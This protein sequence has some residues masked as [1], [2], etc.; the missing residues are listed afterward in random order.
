MKQRLS[1]TSFTVGWLLETL[2][3]R[4][5][6]Y[7][8]ALKGRDVESVSS[9]DIS[10][11]KGFVSCVYKCVIH[12]TGTDDTYRV[13]M[14]VPGVES[15]NK[16][17]D[18]IHEKGGDSKADE[19]MEHFNEIVPRFHKSECTFYEKVAPLV[20]EMPLAKVF[21]T[22]EWTPGKEEGVI[23]MEDLSEKATTMCLHQ[24][25]NLTQVHN[26]ATHLAQFHKSLLTTPEEKWRNL[27]SFERKNEFLT[28]FITDSIP[29]FREI[30]GGRLDDLLDRI[31][32][33]VEN[34]HFL[35]YCDNHAHRKLGI[36]SLLIAG[37]MWTNNIM[38][39]LNEDGGVSNDVQA[40]IDWQIVRE[41]NPMIDMARVLTICCDA[42][43]RREA[44]HTA[45][46]LYYRVLKDGLEKEGQKLHYGLEGL[47]ES[48][49]YAFLH[50]AIHW[51][52][53]VQLYSSTKKPEE[54]ALVWDARIEKT[55]L[56]ARFAL[57][58]ALDILEKEKPEWLD[59]KHNPLKVA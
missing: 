39:K 51:L 44:E 54:D 31:M 34:V 28:N 22:R 52:F 47:K 25:F 4:D 9:V 56:R 8:K 6:A 53:M 35:D 19:N 17:S 46:E 49:K 12:F 26:I 1:N 16:L 48:F 32:P 3:E 57:I 45:L 21:Y 50:Q 18:D 43:V 41:G 11:G 55:I 42:E 30:T 36:P 13:I 2:E 27:Y 58:D 24:T 15:F 14:K 59:A 37:D 33:F 5:E 10:G 29:K 7:R 20:P 23:L 40:L 38:W